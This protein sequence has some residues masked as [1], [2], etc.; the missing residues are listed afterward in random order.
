VRFIVG[1]IGGS[2]WANAGTGLLRISPDVMPATTIGYARKKSAATENL[3]TVPGVR[4]LVI[5]VSNL[6]R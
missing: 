2:N 5:S 4:V 1:T 6:I 3:Q